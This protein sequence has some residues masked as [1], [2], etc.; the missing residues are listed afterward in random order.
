MINDFAL[1]IGNFVKNVTNSDNATG[2]YPLYI[3]SSGKLQVQSATTGSPVHAHSTD[4][5]TTPLK[6]TQA[7]STLPVIEAVGVPSEGLL[8]STLVYGAADSMVTT[9]F[10]RIRVTPSPGD[11]VGT[12]GFYYVP[13]GI[14]A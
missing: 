11:A 4:G 6:A 8:T 3:D 7:T 10:L 13:F 5:S 2:V 9:G 1:R 14:L 12:T